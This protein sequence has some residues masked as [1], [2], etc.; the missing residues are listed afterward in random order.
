MPRFPRWWFWAA[1]LVP[2]V[3][4]AIGLA[5]QA[6][7]IERSIA[8]NVSAVL[9]D[10]TVVV[11]GRDV[12]IG[13]IQAERL[14]AARAMAERAE[15]VREA[16]TKDPE[17]GPMRLLF[18]GNEVTV[19]GVTS[20]PQWRDGFLMAI[21]AQA[22]GRTI[23]NE[24]KTVPGTDFPITTAAAEAVVALITQQPEDMTVSVE[25]G[26]VTVAGVVADNAK[27]TR[28]V[29]VLRRLFGD[30]TLVDKTKPKE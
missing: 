17:L 27:R 19:T 5:I 20:N 29:T 16:S 6:S 26:R 3:I 12:T 25:P 10:V 28:I 18:H 30:G 15:G 4:T 11:H 8:A 1:V 2:A 7:G 22:H 24:T 13:G 14:P 9:P 21:G 23:V